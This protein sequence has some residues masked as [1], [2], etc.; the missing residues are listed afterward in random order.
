MSVKTLTLV[1]E[2]YFDV[3]DLL[4]SG[5]VDD[6]SLTGFQEFNTLR[7]FLLEQ[8]HKL[9]KIELSLTTNQEE[10]EVAK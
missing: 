1:Q 3:C 8:Q 9:E 6:F 7:E 4:N 10:S 5:Q 2:V